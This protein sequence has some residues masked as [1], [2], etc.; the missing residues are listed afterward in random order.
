M[1]RRPSR[2]WRK[3]GLTEPLVRVWSE[4]DAELDLTDHN[5]KSVTISRGSGS[6]SFGPQPHTLEVST[7][8]PRGVRTG[9]R[10]H[11]DLST[12]GAALVG[13][14]ISSSPE[15][16]AK[17]YF[18]R[19]GRQTI[20]DAGGFDGSKWQTT[21]YGASW[22]AQM[23]NTDAEIN[24]VAGT[25]LKS[26]LQQ[27]TAP[28]GVGLPWIPPSES[29]APET[30]YG[31]IAAS[32]DPVAYRDGMRR[33]ATDLGT[34]V[35][36][37]RDGHDRFLPMQYR[38][39]RAVSRLESGLAI[40]LTRSQ[41]VSPATWDQAQESMIRTHQVLWTG[42]DGPESMVTG[43]DTD[44][45]N[46]SVVLY[47]L[48][49]ARWSFNDYQPRHVAYAAANQERNTGYDL[50]SVTIDLLLLM[51]SPHE[52]HRH[53]ARALLQMEMGDPVYLSH[54]WHPYLRGIHFA[55]GIDESF[56]PNGWDITLSL[57][58]SISTLGEWTPDIPP[59][60]WDSAR[61]P[62]ND[63]TREWDAA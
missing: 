51:T 58:P 11:C 50:P 33:W 13:S 29:P 56:S 5:V 57:A 26:F 63:E 32:G 2:L 47:D 25:Q 7:S 10:I 27:L 24:E 48:R 23:N 59:R 42:A 18:G 16:I 55:T 19:V 36:N 53:Q 43:G 17:R 37:C 38:W 49:H 20:D 34:Y 3:L 40:P 62:W 54:D 8:V 12:S 45:P 9:K 4:D 61:Y 30:Q 35:Q 6:P 44:N 52:Y 31:S 60:V 39:D 1:F 15:L 14:L 46:R 22:Q 21:F 41:A 28:L